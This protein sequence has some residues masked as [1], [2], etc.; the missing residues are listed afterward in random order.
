MELLKVQES[1]YFYKR[2]VN[3]K[4]KSVNRNLEM[5][6]INSGVVIRDIESSIILLEITNK[7]EFTKDQLITKIKNQIQNLIIKPKRKYIINQFSKAFGVDL[8]LFIDKNTYKYKQALKLDI[9]A[10]KGH[11]DCNNLHKYIRDNYNK[12]ILELIQ[13]LL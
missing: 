7:E 10:F 8:L 1:N 11:L 4:I 9:E 13:Y 2:K 6:E 3:L 12:E 5:L